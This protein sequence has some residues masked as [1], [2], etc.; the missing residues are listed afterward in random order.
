VFLAD[1]D[2]G[3]GPRLVV[4]SDGNPE[5]LRW[6][7]FVTNDRLICRISAVDFSG[8]VSLPSRA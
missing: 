3:G 4:R 2:Q 7:N 6:C 1:L 8:I 5:R